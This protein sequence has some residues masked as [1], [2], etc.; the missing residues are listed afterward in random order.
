MAASDRIFIAVGDIHG[1]MANL[2]RIPDLSRADGVIV[3]GDL[4]IRGQ[5]PEGK[6]VIDAIRA[7]NPA[8]RAQIGNMD[9]QDIDDWLTDQGINLHRRVA[10]LAPGV[11]LMGVGWSTPT[12]F[13]TPSEISEEDLARWIDD[14]Y[15]LAAGYARLV[16]VV[17][18]PPYNTAT[19]R[20]PS[21]VHVGSPAVRE[22]LVRV[23]P[24]LCVTGHI[25]ESRGQDR[26]GETVVINPG[27]LSAGG[28]VRIRVN[29]DCHEGVAAVLETI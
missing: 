11:G 25:H 17:H 14:T 3:T 23:Q 22:F 2:A 15:A 24:A 6:R 8:V 19:D 16:V 13:G 10:E 26:I 9:N 28:Y 27:P 1:D 12:P 20:L 18:T 21:G 4:T 5:R 29:S 7:I